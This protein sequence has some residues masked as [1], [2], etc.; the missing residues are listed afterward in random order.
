MAMRFFAPT[1]KMMSIFKGKFLLPVALL[2]STVSACIAQGTWTPLANAAPQYNQGVMLQ[3]TDGTVLVKTAAG[4][5]AGI[6]SVWNRL[7]PDVHGSYINGTWSEV[8]GMVDGRLYFSAQVLR[9]GF[10]YVAGGE[11]GTGRTAAE[12]YSPNDDMWFPTATTID[13]G[14]TLSDANSEILPD[15]RVLQ[16][17]VVSDATVSH[18]TYLYDPATF[19]FSP[20]PNTLGLD[21][22]S[23]WVKMKDNSI[24]FA[25][26]YATTTE[27]Y[28]PATNTW[29]P[30]ADLP[31]DLYDAYGYETGAAFMLPDGRA[32]FM[33]STSKSAYYTPSGTTAPGTWTMGPDIPDSL[34]APDAAAAMMPNGKILCAFSH[35]PTLDSVFHTRTMYFEFDYLANVFT[36]V[37]TPYGNDSEEHASYVS[38]M[39]VLPDG[40]ILY[41]D[42]GDDQYFVY[43]PAGAPLAAGKPAISSIYTTTH[44]DTFIA[45]GTLFNGIS[46]GAGYGDDWQMATN[47]PIVRLSRNDSVF[48]ASTYNWN[49]TGIMRGSAPDTTQFV[50]PAGLQPGTYQLQVIANGIASNPYTFSFCDIPA[51]VGNAAQAVKKVNVYPNP[52]TDQAIVE[53]T[54]QHAGEYTISLTDIYGR[55]VMTLP[56]TAT[57]GSNTT[58]IPLTGLAKGVYTITIRDNDDVY[59]TR[60]VVK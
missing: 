33:G 39:L 48:Y 16:A 38:N 59:T 32:F 10:V 21:N 13:M 43:K 52:A 8:V 3:L 46:E 29:V 2:C 5:T 54:T 31:T 1:G 34:G 19:T 18:H 15:G 26:I 40:S 60:V 17:V 55:K 9:N 4:G 45:T 20:G 58:S 25:D 50:L 14:D 27:R 30:D 56:R 47:Y 22:E 41:A 57:I 23:S 28:I 44:C 42:Q 35:T 24:L 11:Y 37:L 51:G 53:Y 6:G 12:I 36:P 49:S 7:T